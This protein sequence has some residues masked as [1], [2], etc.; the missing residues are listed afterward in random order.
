[1]LAAMVGLSY[2][3]LY[4]AMRQGTASERTLT[5]LSW[6]I[7]A[8]GEGRL[9]FRRRRQAWEPWLVSKSALTD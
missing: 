3:T 8:I 7:M 5:K 6:A 4:E 1:M 9:G 2:E